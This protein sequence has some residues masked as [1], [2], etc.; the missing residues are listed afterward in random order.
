[1]NDKLNLSNTVDGKL[2]GAQQPVGCNNKSVCMYECP[3]G[4]GYPRHCPFQTTYVPAN[5]R[6]ITFRPELGPRIKWQVPIT[7][8]DISIE[9]VSDRQFRLLYT[10]ED[11]RIEAYRYPADNQVSTPEVST[12]CSTPLVGN[13]Y[14]LSFPNGLQMV[15]ELTEILPSTPL[16]K[17]YVF[18]FISGDR[19]LVNSSKIAPKFPIPEFMLNR[20]KWKL[21]SDTKKELQ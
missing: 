16:P 3:T 12:E 7:G 18:T 4:C 11:I 20:L 15:A 21:V 2:S 5:Y 13:V 1:M 14:K 10:L 8:T 6:F 9:P 19:Y 17:D